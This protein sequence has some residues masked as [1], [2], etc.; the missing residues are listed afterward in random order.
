M[1]VGYKLS[2]GL[3]PTIKDDVETLPSFEIMSFVPP[4]PYFLLS[5]S[6]LISK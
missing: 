5:M 6:A 4:T 1:T 3:L 2:P